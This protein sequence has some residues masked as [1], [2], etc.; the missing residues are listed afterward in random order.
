MLLKDILKARPYGAATRLAEELGV[1]AN[2]VQRWSSF[3]YEVDSKGA[4]HSCA[5]RV[6]GIMK[7]KNAEKAKIKAL[8]S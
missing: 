1:K 8:Q 3:F 6:A 2:T 7:L 4:I 5:G